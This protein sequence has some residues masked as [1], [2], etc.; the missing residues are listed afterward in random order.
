MKRISSEGTCTY[1]L[2]SRRRHTSCALVTGVQ[3]CALPIFLRGGRKPI[4]EGD[5]VALRFNQHAG[6]RSGE[7]VERSDDA[8]Q[9][10][11]PHGQMQRP[12][13]PPP[14]GTM[15]SRIGERGVDL[16]QHLVQLGDG[17]AADERSEEHT[18]ELQSLIR[19]SYAVFALNKKSKT[20]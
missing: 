1:F 10:R 20:Q 8:V 14:F 3:T 4:V 16:A 17:A 13:M 15:A 6:A 2:S 11:R 7:P 9:P 12:V 19:T 5:A 18:S